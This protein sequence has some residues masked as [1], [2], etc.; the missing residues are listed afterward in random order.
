MA[1]FSKKQVLFYPGCITKFKL[2]EQV[3]LYKKILSRLGIKYLTLTD[4]NFLCCGNK[5]YD[6][7]Y[8]VEARK[9]ARRNFK[10]FKQL[11]INKIITNCP[12]CYRFFILSKEILPD[13][14]IEVEHISISILQALEKR[15]KLIKNP[16]MK[17]QIFY[18]D[19]CYLRDYT[20]LYLEPREVLTLLG[21]E[22][23]ELNTNSTC[24]GACGS[25]NILNPDLAKKITD[26]FI[27]QL[28]KQG[29][30]KLVVVG[31]DC[32]LQLKELGKKN[33]IEVLEFAEV[34]AKGLNLIEEKKEK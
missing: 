28:E 33:E 21:Y 22:L 31:G 25:L 2:A 1:L 11:R 7:G 17:E 23:V 27:K 30:D 12:E 4:N 3:N 34:V 15:K 8:E 6:L 24:C 20:K 26:K 16:V 13:W 9:L 10:I 14:D 29:V 5:L 19:N 32:Y 18:H